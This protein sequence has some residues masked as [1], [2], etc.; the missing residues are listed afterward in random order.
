MDLI[1]YSIDSDTVYGIIEVWMSK[2]EKLIQ[3]FRNNNK[4]VRFE[5]IDTLLI[6]LGF[7]K[8]SSGS[9][10]VY[11]LSGFPPITIPFRTPFILPIYVRN[12]LNVIDD[13]LSED[14]E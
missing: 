11:I 3:R 9:H 14:S 13:L 7:N 1:I 6:S 8:K 12:V 5:E 2:R 10:F 4:A